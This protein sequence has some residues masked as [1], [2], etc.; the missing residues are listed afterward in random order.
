M[1]VGST[2][3]KFD[4]NPYYSPEFPRGGLA[5]TFVIDVSHVNATPDVTVT[6]EHR[7]AEDTSFTTAATFSSITAVG[8]ATKDATSLKEIIRLKF[9]FDAGDATNAAIH[10]LIQAPTWR[11]Y[12]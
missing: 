11:P 8:V 10:F 3:W 2:I 7:N 4:G 12:N 9:E 1:I 5:G 6:I